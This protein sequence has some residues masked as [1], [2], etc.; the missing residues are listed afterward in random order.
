MNTH[1]HT[2]LRSRGQDSYSKERGDGLI[3]PSLRITTECSVAY[4][5]KCVSIVVMTR[6]NETARFSP[7]NSHIVQ[8]SSW[9]SRR[10]H[11]QKNN[12]KE[13]QPAHTIV[14][15]I[16]YWKKLA[17][18]E[19]KMIS[20]IWMA[21]SNQMHQ[22]LADSVWAFQIIKGS[23]N[24]WFKQ[25]IQ[26]TEIIFFSW[27]A[28][29]SRPNRNYNWSSVVMLVLTQLKMGELFALH[30]VHEKGCTRGM[31]NTAHK[32]QHQKSYSAGSAISIQQRL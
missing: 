14:G 7:G 3:Q 29:A 1:T 30:T 27:S 19:K 24:I 21:C 2:L 20:V 15:G 13:I 17:E 28:I 26:I 25:A 23:V 11:K 18:H 12:N 31:L 32:S 4:E 5:I 22:I 10:F 9:L 16:S 8:I 6:R